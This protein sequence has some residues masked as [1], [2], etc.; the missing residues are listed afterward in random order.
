MAALTGT[1]PIDVDSFQNYTLYLS[2]WQYGAKSIPCQNW[3]LAS[4]AAETEPHKD[5]IAEI[6]IW[7]ERCMSLHAWSFTGNT[8]ATVAAL[9]NA[10][11]DVAGGEENRWQRP[12]RSS[13]LRGDDLDRRIVNNDPERIL[14]EQRAQRRLEIQSQV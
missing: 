8:L 11:R 10:R 3:S 5:L 7:S 12:S 1:S 6:A 4:E 13:R 2:R 9:L 14:R